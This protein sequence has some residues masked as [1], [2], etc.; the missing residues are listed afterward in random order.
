MKAARLDRPRQLHRVPR[1]LDVGQLLDLG[2]GGH[3]V[4]RRQVEEVV[5]LAPHRHQ[6]LLGDAQTRLGEVAGDRDDPRPVGPPAGA[7]LLKAAPGARPDER[8]DRPLALQ[9]PLDEVAADEPRRP[10]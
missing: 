7:Q 4:D 2:V 10:G 3:V 8:E 1:A 6:V 5:D 9:Q